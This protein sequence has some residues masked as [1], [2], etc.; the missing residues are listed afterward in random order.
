M[1]RDNFVPAKPNRRDIPDILGAI[2]AKN[3][4]EGEA[5]EIKST[6][7]WDYGQL[8]DNAAA[9]MDHTVAIKKSERRA[10]EAIIQAGEHLIAMKG[11][12]SHGQ[13]GDW[14][15]TEFQMTDRTAQRMMQVAEKFDGKTDKLSD[16]KPSI[17]YMLAAD[18]VPESAREV[19]I[20]QA[21]NGHKV[22][23]ADAKAVISQY[24]PAPA[25]FNNTPPAPKVPRVDDG[26]DEVR[27]TQPI[28]F[29][30][31]RVRKIAGEHIT[32]GVAARKPDDEAI[33]HPLDC[34]EDP[35]YE[36]RWHDP[37][38]ETPDWVA[39]AK[40]DF[41]T[42]DR[43]KWPRRMRDLWELKD[44]FKQTVNDKFEEYRKLTGYDVPA[45][46]ISGLQR[47]MGLLEQEMDG[48]QDG[49]EAQMEQP[50]VNQ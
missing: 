7:S 14:L 16:L 20:E 6:L 32:R 19:V 12:L 31:E 8:G 17:L 1:G 50:H 3:P 43:L 11:M 39:V 4:D 47:M 37:G 28:V 22:T 2:F 30:Y 29:T 44:W 45:I 15:A 9:A 27:V 5:I 24:K 41:E 46:H 42:L 33:E 35:E 26:Y 21:A 18:N 40:Q 36:A 38:T 25:V 10:S 13:W 34:Y 48:L 23:V 49:L